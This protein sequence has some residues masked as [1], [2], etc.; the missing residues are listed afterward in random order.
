MLHDLK[1]YVQHII[2]IYQTETVNQVITYGIYIREKILNN[3]SK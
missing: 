2:F 3:I 1:Y